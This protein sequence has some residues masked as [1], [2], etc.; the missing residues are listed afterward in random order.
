ME[1][2]DAV[3]KVQMLI[4]NELD[5][6]EIQPVMDHIE[7][8]YKCREEYI[9]LLKLKRKL[10]GLKDPAPDDEWFDTLYR[11]KGRR[12]FSR[13]G[14]I[15][16]AASSLLLVGTALFSLFTDSSEGIIIK[17]VVAAAAA[18]LIILFLT[19]LNDRLQEGK[20]DRYKGVMK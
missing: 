16:M 5:E 19:A 14:F 1:C 7:S 15:L 8:C 6:E 12:F 10:E 11:R 20:T 17:I 13:A 4:D 3:M 18:S 9:G 2:D